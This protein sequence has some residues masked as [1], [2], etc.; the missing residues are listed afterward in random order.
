MAAA[1]QADPPAIDAFTVRKEAKQHGTGRR[2]EGPFEAGAAVIGVLAVVDRAEGGLEA[3]EAAG[4]R[5]IA[6]T[7]LPQLIERHA[8]ESG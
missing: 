2:I 1:S 3:I 6:L 8:A 7:H 4:Y 5:T